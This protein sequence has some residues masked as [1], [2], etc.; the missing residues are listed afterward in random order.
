[1]RP[2]FKLCALFITY[3]LIALAIDAAIFGPTLN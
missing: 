3:C 2:E 1:M